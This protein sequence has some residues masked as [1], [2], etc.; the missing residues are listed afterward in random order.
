MHC[1]QVQ[2]GHPEGFPGGAPQEHARGRL[3]RVVRE[4]VQQQDDLPE[5][6][7]QP[8]LPDEV[9]GLQDRALPV[10]GMLLCGVVMRYYSSQ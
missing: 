7:P 1:P 5:P 8:P 2:Q 6:L 4:G 9:Q 3:L 10:S